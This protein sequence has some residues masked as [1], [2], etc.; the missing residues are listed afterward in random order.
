MRFKKRFALL[1]TLPFILGAGPHQRVPYQLNIDEPLYKVTGN[2]NK[3]MNIRL[4][5][6]HVGD[7]ELIARM[8][9]NKTDA[10][11]FSTSFNDTLEKGDKIYTINY[12]LRYRLTGDG[13]RFT[14]QLHHD[15]YINNLQG[16]LYPF[17]Q[18]NIN[19]Q[20]YRNSEYVSEN[21]FIKI[22]NTI[23]STGETF[24]FVNFN[25]YISKNP[26]NSID[27]TSVYFNFPYEYEFVYTDAEY[28][29]KDYNNVY[30]HLKHVDG[31]VVLKM[32]C[33]N[34]D[35]VIHLSLNDTLYVKPDTLDMSS[36]YINGYS[37]TD[38]LFIP[39]EKQA[40]LEEN[41]SYILI[42]EGGYS[43]IDITLPLSYYFNKK[44]LGQCFESDYC[45][46]GGIRE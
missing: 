36:Y 16:V 42:K 8:Y 25:E 34:V 35:G 14:Y 2:A 27:F 9:N 39:V 22:D 43:A 18:V 31:E 1:L 40:L 11:L 4:S 13:I 38:Q 19:A 30:P 33:S 10:L 5:V 23:I 6:Y 7:Y 3:S 41:D 15:Q 44:L 21:R 37:E 28:H 32:S 26:D 24:S 12:P 17:T 45:F 46:E 29:I 20:Q